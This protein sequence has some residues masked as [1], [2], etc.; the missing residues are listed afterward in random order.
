MT[1]PSFVRNAHE[2]A[3]IALAATCFLTLLRSASATVLV[4]SGGEVRDLFG[5]TVSISGTDVLVGA[6]RSGDKGAAFQIGRASCRERVSIA[7]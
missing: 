3:K 1:Y 7:V 4:S 6:L 2:R 5:Q